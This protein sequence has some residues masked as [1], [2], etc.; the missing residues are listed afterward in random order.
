[1]V[2]VYDSLGKFLSYTTPAKARILIKK[3]KAVGTYTDNS[4][5]IKLVKEIVMNNVAEYINYVKVEG[6][7]EMVPKSIADELEKL[8]DVNSLY[9][10]QKS[11]KYKRF[12]KK[13]MGS[14]KEIKTITPSFNEVFD[15]IKFLKT[16]EEFENWINSID[17]KDKSFIEFE[18]RKLW[19]MSHP[20]KT[21]QVNIEPVN[22]GPSIEDIVEKRVKYELGKMMKKIGDELVK[23]YEYEFRHDEYVKSAESFL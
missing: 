17:S 5:S 8:G 16:D 1:M 15:K 2:A 23:K 21:P 12:V 11:S 22:D 6:C 10:D 4:Y 7:D 14:S 9:L 13:L 20:Y 19:D 3:N 18:A